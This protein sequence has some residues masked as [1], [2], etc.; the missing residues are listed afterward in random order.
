VER[1][2]TPGMNQR[3]LAEFTF[4]DI[5]SALN[6]M[7]PLKALA[8]MGFQPASPSRIVPLCIMR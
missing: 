8:Q 1:K 7:A 4:E 5:S 6:Q 3:L 2:V